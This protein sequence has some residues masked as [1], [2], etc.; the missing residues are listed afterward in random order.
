MLCPPA[1]VEPVQGCGAPKGDSGRPRAAEH[2]PGDGERLR[3]SGRPDRYPAPTERISPRM[4]TPTDVQGIMMVRNL[5]RVG[6]D[7]SSQSVPSMAAR[8]TGS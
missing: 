2:L 3:V 6:L 8:P 7:A 4:R 1:K 5:R